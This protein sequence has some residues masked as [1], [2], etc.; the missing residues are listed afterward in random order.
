VNRSSPGWKDNL[1]ISSTSPGKRRFGSATDFG[2]FAHEVFIRT[3]RVPQSRANYVDLSGISQRDC[4]QPR[5]SGKPCLAIH[6]SRYRKTCDF[7]LIG[8]AASGAM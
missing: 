8:N 5:H 4:S 3:R 7:H 6:R 2:G 1:D